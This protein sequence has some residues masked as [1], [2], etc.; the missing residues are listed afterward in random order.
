MFTLQFKV[1]DLVQAAPNYTAA[2]NRYKWPGYCDFKIGEVLHVDH[3]LWELHIRDITSD[4]FTGLVMLFGL[5][6]ALIYL[7]KI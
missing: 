3:L 1:G 6:N 7:I 2:Y 5:Y 4:P